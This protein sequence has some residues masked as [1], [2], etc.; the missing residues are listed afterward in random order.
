MVVGG[1]Q[2][3]TLDP[4]FVLFGTRQ[5]GVTVILRELMLPEGIR[6]RVTIMSYTLMLITLGL[7]ILFNHCIISQIEI[8]SQLKLDH[9]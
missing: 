8:M 9:H 6:S 4:D 7:Y 2:Q 3:E 1:S 5:Q